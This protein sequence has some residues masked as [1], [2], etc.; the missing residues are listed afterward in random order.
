MRIGYNQLLAAARQLDTLDDETFS[1]QY[2]AFVAHTE[3]V[4][5]QVEESLEKNGATGLRG[6]RTHHALLLGALHALTPSVLAGSST[7]ARDVLKCLPVWFFH[8]RVS[9][10]RPA[11]VRKRPSPAARHQQSG[12]ALAPLHSAVTARSFDA[13]TPACNVLPC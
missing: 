9:A 10:P 5:G 2:L 7:A 1:E 4:L 3:M 13:S 8:D 11:A 12:A 6:L